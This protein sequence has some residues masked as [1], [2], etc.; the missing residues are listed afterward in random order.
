MRP[1]PGSSSVMRLPRSASSAPRWTGQRQ[2]ELV[3]AFDDGPEL[4]ET[5]QFPGAPFT[6]DAA[7]CQMD[8]ALQLLHLIAGVSYYKALPP[9]LLIE[10]AL[11]SPALA[12]LATSVCKNGLS[13]RLRNG[14]SMRGRINSRRRKRHRQRLCW[15]YVCA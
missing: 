3:Y 5:L 2:V 1:T 6:L 12:A 8:A 9:Q 4:V 15:V 11:P 13:I 14:L 10:T 7:P